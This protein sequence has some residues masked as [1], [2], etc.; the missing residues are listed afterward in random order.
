MK[1]LEGGPEFLS[2]I[3]TEMDIPKVLLPGKDLI[4][5]RL[6]EKIEAAGKI[7]IFAIVDIITQSIMKPLSDGI[8]KILKTIPMDGTFN[9]GKPLERLLAR[10][11]SGELISP[12]FYSYDLSSA[13][14]RLP[15]LFQ[16]QVLSCFMG[17]DFASEWSSILTK[18]P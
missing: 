7:R 4:L 13:T 2:L 18:R 15:I 1:K 8:F 16:Q 17:E 9:Q 11:K 6:S 5:G 12:I 3:L 14:D 10:V